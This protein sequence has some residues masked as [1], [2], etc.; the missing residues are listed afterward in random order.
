MIDA[1]LRP[2]LKS[3]KKSVQKI[4]NGFFLLAIRIKLYAISLWL[5]A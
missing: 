1:Y 2:M 4:L 5:I 3:K